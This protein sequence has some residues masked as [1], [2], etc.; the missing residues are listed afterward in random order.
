MR[1]RIRRPSVP[2]TPAAGARVYVGPDSDPAEQAVRDLLKHD[3]TGATAMAGLAGRQDGRVLRRNEVGG[4]GVSSRP[5]TL[6]S[7]GTERPASWSSLRRPPGPV[8]S[9]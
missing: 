6:I 9:P 4:L 7:P 2:V 8:S 3:F 5:T 1:L